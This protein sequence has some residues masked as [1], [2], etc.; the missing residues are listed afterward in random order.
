MALIVFILSGGEYLSPWLLGH[1][2]TILLMMLAT[3]ITL[4]SHDTPN[5]SG[6]N[7]MV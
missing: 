3:L 5:C 2:P 1:T 4:V 6:P 7:E